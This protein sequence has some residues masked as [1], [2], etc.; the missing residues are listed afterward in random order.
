VHI[1]ILLLPCGALLFFALLLALP[2]PSKP[3]DDSPRPRTKTVSIAVDYGGSWKLRYK[4]YYN[5]IADSE[6][7]E[8]FGI[9]KKVVPVSAERELVNLCAWLTPTGVEEER[10]RLSL[11]IVVDDG[12]AGIERVAPRSL[13]SN[14]SSICF[15]F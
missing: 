11:S 7:R 13:F 8:L 15:H 1:R 5:E 12:E 14:R 10:E 3:F 6:V 4:I 9:G 2:I